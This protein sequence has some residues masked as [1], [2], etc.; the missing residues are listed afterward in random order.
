MLGLHL[1]KD[2]FVIMVPEAIRLKVLA[3][4]TEL[5]PRE[6]FTGSAKASHVLGVAVSIIRPL[7][8]RLCSHTISFIFRDKQVEGT[9]SMQ[10]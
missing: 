2:E 8:Q 4:P 7:P 1:L 3:G 5:P 9:L 10:T 6:Q